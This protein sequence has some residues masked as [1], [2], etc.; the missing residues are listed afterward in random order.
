[1]QLYKVVNDTHQSFHGGTFDWT[2]YLPTEDCPGPWTPPVEVKQCV[3]GYHVTP[4]PNMWGGTDPGMRVYEVEVVGEVDLSGPGV[5][6]KAAVTSLRLVR[7]VTDSYNTG[8]CNT[9]N[10]NTGGYNTG[11]N[12]GYR[13]TGYRN[14]GD[15]NTGDY[16]TGGWGVANGSVGHFATED[17]SP[18]GFFDHPMPWKEFRAVAIPDWLLHVEYTD[19]GALDYMSAWHRATPEQKQATLDLPF[20]DAAKFEK[21][22]GIKV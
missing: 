4:Y 10:C 2:P 11:Y 9:G 16:N 1:M 6:D 21:I 12:T 13:N 20:F 19:D 7:D 8:N 5:V 22:T 14:T 17:G 15:Y 3:S 18:A